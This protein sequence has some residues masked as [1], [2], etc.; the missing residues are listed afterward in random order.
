LSVRVWPGKPY[1]LGATWDAKGTNFSI[2]SE[3][4]TGVSLLLYE[5]VRA[6]PKET[7]PLTEKTGHVW[8]AYLPDSLPG[9]LY[10]YSMDGPYD[11]RKGHRFNRHKALID[12]YAKAISGK[13]TWDDSLFGY[14]VGDPEEDLS[15]DD[16]DSS[17]YMPKGVTIDPSFDWEGDQLLRTPWNET[18]TYELHVKGFTNANPDVDERIRGSYSGLCS[19]KV[20]QYLKDL[21]ITAIELLPVHQHLDDKFLVDKGLTNYWGYNTIGYLAPHSGYSSTGT[22]GEQVREFKQMVKSLHRAGLEVI[23]DVVY[24]HTAEGNQLG[25]TFSFRGIDNALYYHLSPED[26]RLYVDFTGT[27]NSLNMRNPTSIQLIMDSLRYWVLDMHVDGFRFDLASTL[28][29]ELY[30]VDQLST[31]FEV[32]QQDPV[33]SQVKLIAEP[34]DLGQGG[35]QV[36]NF[37]TL[38]AEWN[39]KYRDAIRRF[40]RGDESQVPELGYRLTGSSDLYQGNGRSPFASVNFFTAHDG[41]TLLDLVSFDH[42]HND[43]NKEENRDGWDENLSWNCGFEGPT[44]DAKVNEMRWRQARNFMTTLFVSQGV[45]MILAGDEIGRTQR[46]NNNAYCQDNEISWV[47]WKL[48]DAK[49]EMLGFTKRLILMRKEHVM[50]RRRRFFQGRKIAGGLKDLMWLQPDGSEM[51]EET[52]SKAK[53]HSIGMM[54]VGYAM[55][56]VNDRGERLLDDTMLVFLNADMQAVHFTVPKFGG[57]WEVIVSS[58][59]AQGSHEGAT[60]ESGADLRLEAH[61]SAVLRRMP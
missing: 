54:L 13:L 34:W 43:A 60:V 7:I 47:D 59:D 1:P 32:I 38:W 41:F 50:L 46:G 23:L 42:K 40:W 28:A 8:H 16:R 57:R 14:K 29:R 26:P 4:A 22:R 20:I 53:A 37:P 19:E 3:N 58:E 2:F 27:G 51:T 12:P 36:G 9:Q 33:I 49:R 56:E 45:P 21:G 30:D 15:F 48:D 10:A 39:G 5:D 17:P 55:E 35:Y 25:P 31:F 61:S 6:N 18:I 24:N 11:P 44:D 52:W